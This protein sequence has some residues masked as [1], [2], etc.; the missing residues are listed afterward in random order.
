MSEG[1]NRQIQDHVLKTG[2]IVTNK[3][4]SLWTAP[5]VTVRAGSVST[6]ETPPYTH[7]YHARCRSVQP[8]I[9]SCTAYSRRPTC[10]S[11]PRTC[12][13]RSP[14]HTHTRSC[15]LAADPWPLDRT[16]C[17]AGSCCY[18]MPARCIWRRFYKV[19]WHTR[20]YRCRSCHRRS[21]PSVMCSRA[22]LAQ[23]DDTSHRTDHSRPHLCRTH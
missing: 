15:P 14:P 5:V 20:R 2:N 11:P 3:S 1:N 8:Y 4:T 10:P 18:C 13:S 23:D 19:C 22:D 21:S 9:V 7:I 16:A 17:P 12:R 6:E